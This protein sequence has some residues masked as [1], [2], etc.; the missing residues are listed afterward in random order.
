MTRK[1]T[2]SAKEN[3]LD[4]QIDLPPLYKYVSLSRALQ[5]FRDREIRMTQPRFLNDPHEMSIE[6][7]PETLI[8]EYY[9][10]IIKNLGYPPKKAAEMA[11]RGL[12]DLSLDIVNDIVKKRESFGILSLCDSPDNMLL[13]AHYAN[14]HKGAVIEIDISKILTQEINDDDIQ[15]LAE[16]QYEEKRIDYIAK[17]IRPWMTLIY[18]GSSWSY[19]REWRLIKSLT[20]LKEKIPD[21]FVAEIPPTA[22][23]QVFLGARA[24]G[25]E[26]EAILNLSSISP[27]YQHVKIHKAMFSSELVGLDFRPAEKYG[28]TILHGEHH[29]GD[30]WRE[31]R[32]WI[33]FDKL[34][35]A[36]KG[37]GLL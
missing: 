13:W 36:E 5:I 35:Q 6:I 22:I 14:E 24:E 15:C 26:E 21:I 9:Q 3:P 4:E 37:I 17:K 29:F 32:Q 20:L 8:R 18:K 28:W 30:Q 12:L 16:V 2:L 34:E 33:N 11:K 23:K 7:N 25:P 27:D 19:E 10:S 1:P 31:V